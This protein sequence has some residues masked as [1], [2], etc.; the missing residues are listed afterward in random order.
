MAGEPFGRLLG[1]L[2]AVL[3]ALAALL[4]LATIAFN[5]LRLIAWRD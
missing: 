5:V 4:F 3:L 1:L 2:E